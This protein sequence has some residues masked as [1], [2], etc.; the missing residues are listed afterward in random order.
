MDKPTSRELLPILTQ[1]SLKLGLV[2]MYTY[3]FSLAFIGLDS[4]GFNVP[5]YWIIHYCKYGDIFSIKVQ[6]QEV[7]YHDKRYQH[8]K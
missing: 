1:S 7:F 4:Y 8:T 6:C 3:P 5:L 2:N